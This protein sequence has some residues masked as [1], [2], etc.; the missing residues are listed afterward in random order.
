MNLGIVIASMVRPGVCL[1]DDMLLR[2]LHDFTK[3]LGFF[4]V[5]AI[6]A[7]LVLMR[8]ESFLDDKHE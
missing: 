4:S 1:A 5:S 6:V 3:A 2:R 7:V 8:T